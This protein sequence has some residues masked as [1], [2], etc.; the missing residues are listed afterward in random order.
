MIACPADAPKVTVPLDAGQS[1]TELDTAE[2]DIDL[3]DPHG[4]RSRIAE[5][6]DNQRVEVA[7]AA[8]GTLVGRE[9]SQKG[10]PE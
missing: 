1:M 2:I 9:Y 5:I 8:R 6:I 3:A 7:P 10:K 4:S